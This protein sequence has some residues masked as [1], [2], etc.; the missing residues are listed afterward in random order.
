MAATDQTYRNQ[1]AL[2]IVFAVSCLLMLASI[3]WMFVQDYNREFKKVQRDFRDVEEAVAER[4]MLAKLPNADD[5]QKRLDQ[6][7]AARAAV[8]AAKK[9][10]SAE[11]QRLLAAK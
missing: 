1:K 8:E 3:V 6:V 11:S 7:Y 2:D 5:L 9:S 10:T 4:T